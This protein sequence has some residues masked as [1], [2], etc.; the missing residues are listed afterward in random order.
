VIGKSKQAREAYLQQLASA[1][2][3][4]VQ[5]ANEHDI[6][7]RQYKPP[8][9]L[10]AIDPDALVE[11]YASGVDLDEGAFQILDRYLDAAAAQAK[12][13]LDKQSVD[14]HI[15][16]IRFV[17]ATRDHVKSILVTEGLVVDETP[18]TSEIKE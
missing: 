14:D 2:D 18:Q 5:A 3:D 10:F 7:T 9:W 4:A 17:Q 12:S 15:P 1:Y 6:T 11:R 8:E 16:R 13:E